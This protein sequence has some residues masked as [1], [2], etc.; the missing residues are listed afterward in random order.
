MPGKQAGTQPGEAGENKGPLRMGGWEL[1][2]PEDSS[3]CGKYWGV[4]SIGELGIWA[5]CILFGS[6]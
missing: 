3:L 4:F 5:T 6:T 2:A 1:L